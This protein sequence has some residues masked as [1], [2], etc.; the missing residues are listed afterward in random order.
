MQLIVFQ[1]KGT[2]KCI[3]YANNVDGSAS[4]EG[5]AFIEVDVKSST[6]PTSESASPDTSTTPPQLVTAQSGNATFV[7]VFAVSIVVVIVIIGIFLLARFRGILCFS[8]NSQ[9]C[10]RLRQRV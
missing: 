1:D 9:Y 4:V 6:S 7:I 5:S 3:I 8:A 2:W 10:L